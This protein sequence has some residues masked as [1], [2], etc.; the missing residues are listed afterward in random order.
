MKV[1]KK[2]YVYE[3]CYNYDFYESSS[4]SISIHKTPKGAKNAMIKH[5]ADILKEYDNTLKEYENDCLVYEGL[6]EYP[7]DYNKSWEIRKTELLH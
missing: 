7:W 5:K 6:K 4:T 3:F 1:D 2:E